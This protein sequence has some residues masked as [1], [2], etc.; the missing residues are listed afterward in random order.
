M[1]NLIT[2]LHISLIFISIINHSW[3]QNAKIV[4]GQSIDIRS[5]PYQV[6]IEYFKSGRLSQFCGGSI[7]SKKWVVSVRNLI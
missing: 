4:G 6:A 1:K 3:S 2:I 5:A 7:I